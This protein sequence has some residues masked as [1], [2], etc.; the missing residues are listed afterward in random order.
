MLFNLEELKNNI[1]KIKLDNKVKKKNKI[2]AKGVFVKYKQVGDVG[3]ILI[4]KDDILKLIK[5]ETLC[6]RVSETEI[7]GQ[8]QSNCPLPKGSGL[9][10]ISVLNKRNV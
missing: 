7:S 9:H 4:V 1:P 10:E 6:V 5:S 2:K 3:H 8:L